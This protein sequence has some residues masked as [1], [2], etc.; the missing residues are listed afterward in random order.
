MR[1]PYKQIW[2]YYREAK[3][4]YSLHSPY[5]YSFYERVM[6][7]TSS[8]GE[9]LLIERKRKELLTSSKTMSFVE[10]GA[11]SRTVHGNV[12]RI[13]DV[14]RSSLSGQWQCQ[15]IHNLL[16][17]HQ[18]DKVLEIGTSLGVC[19]AYMAM[20][21]D[22][23]SL[24]TLEGNPESARIAGEVLDKLKIHNTV[25]VEG[26]FADTLQ[27]TLEVMES[28]DFAFI[29]GNHRRD[30]TIEYFNTILGSCSTTSIIIIDD[31]YWSEGMHEAWTT[32]K[33]HPAVGFSIDLFRMGI[34]YLD[35]SVMPIQHFQLIDYRYKPWSIGV[36][37]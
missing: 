23:S 1:T 27:P 8:S 15:I 30:A 5:L 36:F 28:V 22:D 18:P 25:I 19:A 26:D 9:T 13:C 24:Y 17:L 34:I 7:D 6:K 14:A 11:G 2:Q 10:L 3:T 20:A 12:R 29:D 33:A 21:N 37:G 31:I 16:R 32:I 35:Q 4:K